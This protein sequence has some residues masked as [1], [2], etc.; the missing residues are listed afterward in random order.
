MARA[1]I[2]WSTE[3]LGVHIG[4]LAQ[5]VEMFFG[6]I[7]ENICRFDTEA[8]AEDILKAAEA[9]DVHDL[10]TSLPDGYQTRVGPGIAGVVGRTAAENSSRTRALPRAVSV[11]LDEPN[12]SLDTTGEAAL[13]QAIRGIRE[14]GGIVV[15][16]SHRQARLWL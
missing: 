9:A 11:V 14:R 4:Y 10:I 15:V 6:T 8:R 12:S 2:Q 3:D 16:I 13:S 7:A 1:L 5:H